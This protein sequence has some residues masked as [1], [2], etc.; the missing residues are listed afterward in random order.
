MNAIRRLVKRQTELYRDST[1]TAALVAE[2]VSDGQI[3]FNRR[4]TLG[5]RYQMINCCFPL[6]DLSLADMASVAVPCQEG[7]QNPVAV[8]DAAFGRT[9]QVMCPIPMTTLPLQSIDPITVCRSP[10]GFLYTVGLQ[11]LLAFLLSVG[12]H[13]I[14]YALSVG[15]VIGAV[16]GPSLGENALF[17]QPVVA[18][19]PFG[20]LG[21][22]L[23]V[24]LSIV[25]IRPVLVGCIPDCLGGLLTFPAQYTPAILG[26]LTLVEIIERFVLAA[27][28]ALLH[29]WRSRCSSMMRRTKSATGIP[30]RLASAFKNAIWG[31][32]NEIICLYIGQGYHR[33]C[34]L[35][36]VC[37]EV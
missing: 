13:P 18:L 35:S 29:F 15:L 20:G 16:V 3:P 25:S 21:F 10:S 4:A 28:T 33:V 31:S 22:I 24:V 7:C 23:L 8:S 19:P 14:V 32:V 2:E 36:R 6:P 17:L 12:C 27:L 9:N 5:D 34:L 30:R 26:Q 11:K 37:A 1:I